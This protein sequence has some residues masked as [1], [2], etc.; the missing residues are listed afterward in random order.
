LFQIYK[1]SSSVVADMLYRTDWFELQLDTKW[2]C[3]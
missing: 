2:S 1:L 3:I